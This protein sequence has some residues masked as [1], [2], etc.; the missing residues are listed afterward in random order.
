MNEIE[1]K[2]RYRQHRLRIQNATSLIDSHVPK[3]LALQKK[4]HEPKTF[5]E[6]MMALYRNGNSRTF[7]Q[8]PLRQAK[9]ID[10]LQEMPIKL[11]TNHHMTVNYKKAQNET[12]IDGKFH[13][14]RK[15]T[16]VRDDQKFSYA[17]PYH[18]WQRYKSLPFVKCPNLLAKLLRPQIFM[19]LQW[20]NGQALG[21]LTV[22]LFTEACPEIVAQFVSTCWLR[23]HDH[24]KF[25]RLFEHLW[26]EGELYLANKNALTIPN[27]EHDAM[28]IN[29][30]Q[31]AGILSFPSRYLRGSKFRFISFTLSFKPLDVLNGR[32][33][34]FGKIRRGHHVLEQL[35]NF[36]QRHNGKPVNEVI[37][38]SCGVL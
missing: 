36:E 12:N 29:H 17:I 7:T 38:M 34:A 35:Q 9:S 3:A 27:I 22:Q 31:A 19:D 28:A 32:R 26:L 11:P 21:R 14:K 16:K 25:T 23:Q 5:L 1:R 37:V 33:I 13:T 15:S 24:F 4:N 30:G 10:M 2:K 8:S 6:M 18:I 20:S